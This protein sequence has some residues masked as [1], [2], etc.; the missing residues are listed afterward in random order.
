MVSGHRRTLR[1]GDVIA[2]SSARCFEDLDEGVRTTMGG[3]DIKVRVIRR[4]R[5]AVTYMRVVALFVLVASIVPVYLAQK[6]S[7][8]AATGVP[9]GEK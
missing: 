4:L 6:L 5:N 3:V 2:R 7:R 1:T 8:G 9:V